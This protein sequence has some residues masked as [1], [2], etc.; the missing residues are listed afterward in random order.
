MRRVVLDASAALE[1]V[2][3]G[4][5]AEGLVQGLRDAQTVMVPSLFQAEVANALWKYVRRGGLNQD[6]AL[7]RLGMATTLADEVVPDGD[8]VGGALVLASAYDHRVYDRLYAVVAQ[9][10]GCSGCTLDT[11]LAEILRDLRIPISS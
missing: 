1:L 9:R 11:R 3:G 5:R 8:V 4:H 10:F 6:E 7:K 2:L